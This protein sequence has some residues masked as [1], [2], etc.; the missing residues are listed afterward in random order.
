MIQE[1]VDRPI[2][3]A[4]A[5][6]KYDNCLREEDRAKIYEFL[7]QPTWGFGWKSDPMADRFSFWH[8][9]FAGLAT[10]DHYET[11]DE[12]KPYDCADEL[13]K[14]A[15]LLFGLWQ[16]LSA[17]VL[18]GHRLVRSYANGHTYGS[19]GSVH[20]DSVAPNSY[21]V[22]YYPHE[23]WSPNW[24]GETVFFNQEK[25]DIISSVYPRPNRMVAFPGTIPHVAR[26][27]SRIC[28]LMRITLM[29]KTE[30]SHA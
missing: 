15:P 4:D 12:L 22:I 2:S 10:P 20:T 11:R 8:K 1:L 14:S 27:V 24:G 3:Q 26:G 30:F 19:D 9:H 23:R 6:L 28:P 7:Q 16:A 29:Y 21:T 18:K 13:A 25:T 17:T 5:V